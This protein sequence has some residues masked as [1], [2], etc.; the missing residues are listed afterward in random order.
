MT[1]DTETEASLAIA[2]MGL[3]IAIEKAPIITPAMRKALE[4]AKTRLQAIGDQPRG[5]A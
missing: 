5:I 4:A 3:I 1:Y 2:I